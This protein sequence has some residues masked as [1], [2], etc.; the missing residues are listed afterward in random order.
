[1]ARVV[2]DAVQW[3]VEPI[4]RHVLYITIPS[5]DTLSETQRAAVDA[6]EKY[7][8]IVEDYLPEHL[9][10]VDFL[11]ERSLEAWARSKG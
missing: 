5:Y 11:V 6:G 4:N 7:P 1:M 2:L 10:L 3:S 8:V 9:S